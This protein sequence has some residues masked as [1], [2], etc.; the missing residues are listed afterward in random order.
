MRISERELGALLGY[1]QSDHLCSSAPIL[2]S[3]PIYTALPEMCSPPAS[4]DFRTAIIWCSV[5]GA[6]R[7]AISSGY[8][9]VWMKISE[10]EGYFFPGY[11]YLS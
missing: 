2:A 7:M 5:N 10:N 1:L 11:L 6:L 9:S 8:L 4:A 3:V